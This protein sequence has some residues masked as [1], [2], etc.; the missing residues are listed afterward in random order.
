MGGFNSTC[1]VDQFVSIPGGIQEDA[2]YTVTAAVGSPSDF[3][4]G[5]YTMDISDPDA[6]EFAYINDD[7][8][9]KIPQESGLWYDKSLSFTGAWVE[10]NYPWEIGGAG[11]YIALA[12]DGGSGPNG[13]GTCY[14][15]VRLTVT[16][17]PE[18][19]ALTLLACGVFGLWACAWRR[20]AAN[21]MARAFV[22]NRPLTMGIIVAVALFPALISAAQASP[23]P[24]TY[25][26][27]PDCQ[28]ETDS[29]PQMLQSDINW[30]VN[31]QA[32]QNI[33]YV[34]CTGDITNASGA[35]A[36]GNSY[37]NEFQTAHNIF[38]GVTG[39]PGLTSVSGLAW[40]TCPGD[41]DSIP[42]ANGA[43]T[44]YLTSFGP[45]NFTGQ[46][47]YGG[48]DMNAAGTNGASSYQIFQ[49]G[50]RSYLVLQM[51]Y[52]QAFPPTF[53]TSEL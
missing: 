9:G 51:E 6:D 11:I 46:S 27:I 31:N 10:K 32:S 53:R 49:A 39:Q 41:H 28:N 7:T 36:P 34:G 37:P 35:P 21:R 18:P 25:V 22:A 50:G 4:H 19:S 52:H 43:M 14:T 42:Q 38:F 3:D 20:R 44:N 45:T 1:A 16:T 26:D 2:T 33:A 48:D 24:F 17:V 23:A 5:G 29:A 40:G 13:A 8:A 30:I 12:G 47:W 15:N